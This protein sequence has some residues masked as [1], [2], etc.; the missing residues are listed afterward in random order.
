M[1]TYQVLV[2]S[3]AVGAVAVPIVTLAVLWLIRRDRIF[4]N[5]APGEIPAEPDEAPTSFVVPGAQYSGEVPARSAPPPGVSPGLGGVVVDGSA[6][7]RDI[8]AMIIDLTHRGWLTLTELPDA[9]GH[10]W[11]ISRVDRPLDASLDL[12]EV[13]L[14]T[15]V[16]PVGG[17]ARLSELVLDGDTRLGLLRL[18]M[19][20]EVVARGW[21]LAAPAQTSDIPM[22][23][24]GFG[25][26]L[27]IVLALIEVSPVSI[28]AGAVIV[29]C[30]FLTSLVVRGSGPRTAL[31]TA[32]R[33][34]TLGLRRHLE[35]SRGYQI[36]YS[37]AAAR[38][39]DL[40]AWA[41]VFDL[42]DHWTEVFGR[43]DVETDVPELRFARDPRWLSHLKTEA[44]VS[45]SPMAAAV[46]LPRR[47]AYSAADAVS[48]VLVDPADVAASSEPAEVVAVAAL[49]A[50]GTVPSG[51]VPAPARPSVGGRITQ[52]LARVR[53]ALQ[54]LLPA[55]PVPS[56]AQSPATPIRVQG[57]AAPVAV[58]A[59]DEVAGV[60]QWVPRPSTKPLAARTR[61]P[62]VPPRTPGVAATPAT[63]QRVP[64]PEEPVPS[65][66]TTP[67]APATPSRPPVTSPVSVSGAGE[68]TAEDQLWDSWLG[69]LDLAMAGE[70]S[71]PDD[72]E[73]EG[74]TVISGPE[75]FDVLLAPPLWPD[76]PVHRSTS[77][78]DLPQ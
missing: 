2:T 16:A 70:V 23:I 60:R 45:P 20:R 64:H 35:E 56:E 31:G 4:S 76:V 74:G 38:F 27:G 62:V 3:M 32:I 6:D 68:P 71:D 12:T 39:R 47:R 36:S 63:P 59:A 65:A 13:H 41:V 28:G 42:V 37:D 52:V 61:T 40:L 21:Y 19:Y 18:D 54:E 5:V 58:P 51:Q 73:T 53:G 24:L 55:R 10:D 34:Q 43:L 22:A 14:I 49:S 30:S 11:E 67:A 57:P 7:G 69:E 9:P 48:T 66:P 46:V 29:A 44:A 15:N 77:R 25:G 75:R 33:I 78:T 17:S 1:S 26:L 8:A 72:D 50:G